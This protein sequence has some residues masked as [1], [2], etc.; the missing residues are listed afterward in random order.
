M[1]QTQCITDTNVAKKRSR[2][3][4]KAPKDEDELIVSH[5][6]PAGQVSG[7]VD[8]GPQKESPV[9]NGAVPRAANTGAPMAPAA[10]RVELED[11]RFP[12]MQTAKSLENV[13]AHVLALVKQERTLEKNCSELE[14]KMRCVKEAK[15][16]LL[17]K[18]QLIDEST[19]IRKQ[20]LYIQKEELKDLLEKEKASK[21]EGKMLEKALKKKKKK[22]KKKEAKLQL[23]EDA[24]Q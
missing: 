6:C 24:L 15:A 16:V 8:N 5:P 13:R 17:K 20:I 10:A 14:K 2:I 11:A 23:K 7:P 4:P 1:R 19:M 22:Y 21:E 12:V 18:K 9:S 3:R